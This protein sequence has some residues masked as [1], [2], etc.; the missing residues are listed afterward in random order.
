ME[1]KLAM[2]DEPVSRPLTTRESPATDVILAT[3]ET[4]LLNQPGSLFRDVS[5][6]ALVFVAVA[7]IVWAFLSRE[8]HQE[9]PQ[10]KEAKPE[11]SSL[12]SHERWEEDNKPNT[13]NQQKPGPL[14]P[15]TIF[16]QASPAVVQVV[17]QDRGGSDYGKASG[18]IAKK[19]G[20]IV[21][22]YHVIENSHKAYVV[23]SNKTRLPVTGVVALDQEADLAIIKV[24]GE[25]NIQPLELSGNDLPAVGAKVYA[26]G[27]PH[28]LA[29]SLSDGLVSAHREKGAIPEFPY[30]PTMIQTTAPISP[31][32]SG[33]PLLGVDGKVVGITTIGSGDKVQNLNFAIPA[34]HVRWLLIRCDIEGQITQLPL[35]QKPSHHKLARPNL[36]SEKEAKLVEHIKKRL[37]EGMT[38]REVV[39]VI[40]ELAK[41]A[42]CNVR[43]SEKKVAPYSFIVKYFPFEGDR[44]VGRNGLLYRLNVLYVQDRLQDWIVEDH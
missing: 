20:M 37:V 15:D 8:P 11:A 43:W 42:K 14:S 33:G 12:L 35:D 39:R 32:S 31:G 17:V 23:L 7:A 30:M 25:I 40:D 44:G 19:N 13:S 26:I 2:A 18:Y 16:A 34:T 4:P 21:T 5:I 24:A 29:N 9:A 36:A 28:G 41:E 22:N 6:F 3:A 10:K 38:S 1:R 27:N